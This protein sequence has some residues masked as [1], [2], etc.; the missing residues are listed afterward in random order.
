MFL[1]RVFGRRILGEGIDFLDAADVLGRFE[2]GHFLFYIFRWD[3]RCEKSCFDGFPSPSHSVFLSALQ[4]F[5]DIFWGT[6]HDI[7]FACQI[8]AS[9]LF[10]L[11]I[12]RPIVLFFVEVVLYLIWGLRILFVRKTGIILY[13]LV[14]ILGWPNILEYRLIVFFHL[15]RC[16]FSI[17]S[18]SWSSKLFMR[19]LFIE[20]RLLTWNLPAALCVWW[21]VIQYCRR[22][23]GG[24]QIFS[25]IWVCAWSSTNWR[26]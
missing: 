18:L 25:W 2:A 15:L 10:F 9:R 20:V 23:F 1:Y 17:S 26:W 12:P 22:S 16:Y 13:I 6:F 19:I 8:L 7:W 4:T 24:L 14:D 3:I 11:T 5:G 21:R